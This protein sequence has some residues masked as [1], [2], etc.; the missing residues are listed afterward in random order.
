MDQTIQFHGKFLNSSF[1]SE[2]TIF[3]EVNL[4]RIFDQELLK[5][6]NLFTENLEHLRGEAV[7]DFFIRFSF[8]NDYSCLL[9]RFSLVNFY[10]TCENNIKINYFFFSIFFI[11]I[12]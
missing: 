8:F 1:L 12:T 6:L 3:P 5:I 9:F 10:E 7:E 11:S 2:V 4:S